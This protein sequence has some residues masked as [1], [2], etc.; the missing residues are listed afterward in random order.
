MYTEVG[1]PRK[2]SANNLS[3]LIELEQ[4]VNALHAHDGGDCPELGMTGILNALNL[5]NPQS[6]VI[7]L[8]DASPKDGDKKDLVIRAAYEKETSIHF[9]L[10]RTGCGNFTPYLDVARETYGVV[11]NQIV[12]FEAFATFVA[13]AKERYTIEYDDSTNIIR[14]GALENC[15]KFSVSVFTKSIDI[16]FSSVVTRFKVTI[17]TPSGSLVEVLAL[18]TIAKYSKKDPAAGIYKICSRSTF[19]HSISTTSDLDFFVEYD[20]NTSRTLL[21]TPGNHIVFTILILLVITDLCRY[22]S[23]G[24]NFFLQN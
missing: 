13:R 1:V 9:L 14:R 20:V 10:S 6:N 5:S 7:V 8:T 15:V 2:Y 22:S 23:Q 24:N 17:I 12:D 3:E 4:T 21:P 16:L 18:G 19:K 11:V